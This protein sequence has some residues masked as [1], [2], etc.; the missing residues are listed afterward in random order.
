MGS[1]YLWAGIMPQHSIRGD[2]TNGRGLLRSHADARAK[3]AGGL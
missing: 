2:N 3:A 1:P